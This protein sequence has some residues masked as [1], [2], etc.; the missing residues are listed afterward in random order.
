MKN[1]TILAVLVVTAFISG[2]A[3]AGE[4][5][6]NPTEINNNESKMVDSGSGIELDVRARQLGVGGWSC[7]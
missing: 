5:L 4:P 6:P 7:S 2:V 3:I 1:S